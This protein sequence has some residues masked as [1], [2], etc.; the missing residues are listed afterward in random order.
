MGRYT[1]L[2]SGGS[3]VGIRKGPPSELSRI[4]RYSRLRA[5]DEMSF[6]QRIVVFFAGRLCS[7]ARAI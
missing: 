5:M 3:V 1:I 7:E 6:K 4:R 2:K